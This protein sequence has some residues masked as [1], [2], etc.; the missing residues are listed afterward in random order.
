[1][2][3]YDLTGLGTRSFEHMV[4]ALGKANIAQGLEPFGDGP[5][6][7]REAIFEGV[8]NYPS[9]SDNW[10]G[11]LV[12]Q[13]KFRQR[14]AVT[15]SVN[16]T[17][18]IKQI[19]EDLEKFLDPDRNLRKPDYYLATPNVSLTSTADTGTRD[20]VMAI[21]YEYK[22][23]LDLKG[24]DVWAHDDLCRF[25][26]GNYSVRKAYSNLLTPGDGLTALAETARACLDVS[27]HKNPMQHLIEKFRKEREED[28]VFSGF[29][30]K[31]QH[32]SSVIDLPHDVQGL[33][34]KLREGKYD[35]FIRYATSTKE[36]FAMKL[37][38]FQFSRSAQ[39]ILSMLL[40][41]VYTRFSHRVW[42]AICESV[43]QGVILRLVQDEVIEP[44]SQMV[45]ENV[46]ELYTDELTGMLYF[47]TGNCHIK[48]K[49]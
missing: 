37:A 34:S 40:A 17:W 33:E 3:D 43:D 36:Q 12:V 28:E 48:W 2:P 10:D 8:M 46:L 27:T 21:L 29:I 22:C 14:P 11:Y 31:L 30:P 16:G 20:R 39:E 15:P 7:A 42:P 1:M 5:D 19:S 25:L 38:E 13:S 26:D 24:V 23:K 18:F 9:P 32:Y 44:I 45:D 35:H 49:A 47:L 4:Q 6:G 41:E